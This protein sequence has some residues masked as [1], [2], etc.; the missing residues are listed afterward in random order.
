MKPKQVETI[1][2]N[3]IEIPVDACWLETAIFGIEQSFAGRHG[4]KKYIQTRQT[5]ASEINTKLVEEG[6][7]PDGLAWNY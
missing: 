1:D 6:I 2:V 4:L 3:G 7:V 5:L